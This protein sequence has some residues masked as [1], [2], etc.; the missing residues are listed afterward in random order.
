[1]VKDDRTGGVKREG[2][3]IG[4]EEEA[5]DSQ[6]NMMNTGLTSTKEPNFHFNN[7]CVCLL[8]DSVL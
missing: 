3:R 2:D 5:G 4:D 6:E 7:T 8:Q 1:M